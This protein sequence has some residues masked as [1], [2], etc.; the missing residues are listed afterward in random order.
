M[1]EA[2]NLGKCKYAHGY[3]EV[4]PA[5]GDWNKLLSTEWKELDPDIK[6]NYF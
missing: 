1:K 6:R 3:S 5:F 4:E 2:W